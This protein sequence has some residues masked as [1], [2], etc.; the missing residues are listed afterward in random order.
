VACVLLALVQLPW[1]GY[2]VGVGNQGIQIAFLEKLRDYE[3]LSNDVMITKTMGAYPSFFFHLCAKLLQITQLDFA[4][5][6]LW[7]HIAA[8]AGVFAAT[9]GLAR[10]MTR[11]TW[12]ALVCLLLLLAGHHQALAGEALYSPG[13]THTW[14]MFPWSLLAL[15]FFFKDRHLAAFLLSGLIF[16]FHALEAGHLLLIMSFAALFEVRRVGWRMLAASAALFLVAAA[17]TITLM[18][19]RNQPPAD[20]GLWLELMHIRSAD[21]SFPSS[22]WQEGVSDIP[23]FACILG[24]AAVALG[25]RLPPRMKRKTLLLMAAIGILFVVGTV[26]TDV[27]PVSLVIRAQFFRSSRLLLVIALILIAH[28]CAVALRLPWHKVATWKTVDTTGG[29]GGFP[30]DDA[31]PIPSRASPTLPAWGAYLEF[32]NALFTLA[33]L[34]I[35]SMLP[36]LPAALAVAVI[37]A[38]INGRLAWYE[39]LLAGGSLLVCLA[40]YQTIQFPILVPGLPPQ[41]LR[42]LMGGSG[43]TLS[44]WGFLAVG[45][46]LVV[47]ATRSASPLVRYVVLASGLLYTVRAVALTI[48]LLQQNA[49]PDHAWLEIQQWAKKNTPANAI[50]L[51]RPQDS[52]FRIYSD[53]AV[54]GEWRDGTQLYFNGNF[55]ADWWQRMNALQPGIVVNAD[56]K[57]LLS[58]GKSLDQLDDEHIVQLAQQFGATYVVLPRSDRHYLEQAGCQNDEWTVFKAKLAD[59]GGIPAGDVNLPEEDKFLRTTA[60]PNI[61]RYRKSDAQVTIVDAAGKPIPGVTYTITQTSS[62]FGFGCSLPFFQVP[63]VDA[64]SD[65]L[66]PAVTP[67]ELARF[68]EVFNYSVIPFSSQWRVLEPVKGQADF[69][70]LDQY[71]D[72]CVANRV[73]G[74]FRFL[75]GYPPAWYKSTIPNDQLSILLKHA[76]QLAQR[77]GRKLQNWQITSEDVGLKEIG[78]K[79]KNTAKLTDFFKELR[80]ALPNARLG[81]ADDGRFWSSPLRTGTAAQADMLRGLETLK[82]LKNAGIPID[83]WAIAA[84]HPLGLWASGQQIYDTL[85]AFAKEG[86]A[87]L[88]IHITEFGVAVGDRIEGSVRDGTWD[89]KTRAEYYERFFTICFSHPNV[90]V[91][92]VMGIGPNT[93]LEGQGLLDRHYEPTLA[94]T[95]LKDLIT[96]RWRTQESGTLAPNGQVAF[97]GFHGDYTLAVTLPEDKTVTAPFTIVAASTD[98]DART[99]NLLRF[100]YNAASGTLTRTDGPSGAGDHTPVAANEGKP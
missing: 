71:V 92:N 46:T 85:N 24:L 76:Q 2:Q 15:Y 97:R 77:Y 94:F 90:E 5:L 87:D 49:V 47:F 58:R 19:V 65:Y 56:K 39:A 63:K 99:S 91:I 38:L 68:K 37:V 17:P 50:F 31:V 30:L 18:V 80:K 96:Q 55:A 11:N 67:D 36:A 81:I 33:C 53:R 75:A 84:K 78:L 34:A 29:T 41:N 98:A 89:D 54:V 27:Y 22:W 16:N 14:A 26:F 8:T 20:Y 64:K 44:G 40:A 28:G 6:Y 59:L 3:L 83:Y 4:T 70:D 32:A 82:T 95:R 51:T 88:K 35:P 100:T 86:G 48:L 79:D 69:T 61:E 13:F 23:R 12:T 10:A 42:V 7:L 25:F 73:Q 1:A 66:P 72:W 74:E 60:L 45:V 62:T 93:W 9:G 43:P 57:T 21:H 52:G